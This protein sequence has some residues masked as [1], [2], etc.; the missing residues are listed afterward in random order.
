ML[1]LRLANYLFVIAIG[2]GMVFVVAAYVSQDQTA[3]LRRYLQ[4]RS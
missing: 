4:Q 2:I 3:D 1:E